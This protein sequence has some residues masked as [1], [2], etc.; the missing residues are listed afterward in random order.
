M[1]SLDELAIAWSEACF[2]A[3][4]FHR[5]Q[6]QLLEGPDLPV[7]KDCL[8][9]VTALSTGSRESASFDLRVG[10][11][12]AVH[13]G[14]ACLV[15]KH[16]WIPFHGLPIVAREPKWLSVIEPK[17]LWAMSQKGAAV[18][19][20]GPGKV[21]TPFCWKCVCIIDTLRMWTCTRL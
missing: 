5:I 2:T 6:F 15:M 18:V 7:T 14:L 17:W 4:Q 20:S 3:R 9:D 21:A 12:A 11:R 1:T 16:Y 8:E 10:T 13:S 19:G